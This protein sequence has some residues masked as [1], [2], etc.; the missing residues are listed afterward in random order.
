MIDECPICCDSVGMMPKDDC[1]NLLH[2]KT[3]CL[4]MK[5][6]RDRAVDIMSM[7]DSERDKLDVADWLR[8]H[9]KARSYD[10]SGCG[11]HY[12]VPS[13]LVRMT[14][15]CGRSCRLRHVGGIDPNE[16]VIDAAIVHFGNERSA[17]LA[18]VA[19]IIVSEHSQHL[20]LEDAKNMIRNEIDRW[21]KTSSGW[22][23][24]EKK[25]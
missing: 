3:F 1:T 2:W 14:C 8:Q 23:R 17:Q 24:K 19:E 16:E 4:R 21:Y 20:S 10:C 7:H 9:E 11:R 18:W 5:N 6:D 25:S 12:E 22:H 13:H 15:I